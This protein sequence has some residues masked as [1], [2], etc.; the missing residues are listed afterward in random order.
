MK[1]TVGRI[2]HFYDHTRP[3]DASGTPGPFAAIVTAVEGDAVA[4]T[5]FPVGYPP[6]SVEGVRN[7]YDDSAVAAGIWW[8]LP[9]RDLL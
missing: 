3:R 1:P 7:V 5:I 6:A 9:P 4:L 2:V 8:T